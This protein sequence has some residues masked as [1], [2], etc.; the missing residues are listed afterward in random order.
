[1]R[2]TRLYGLFERNADGTRTRLAPS[3][4]LPKEQAIRLWQNQ[5]LGPRELRPLPKRSID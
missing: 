2:G 3:I 4:A 1:M 5:L